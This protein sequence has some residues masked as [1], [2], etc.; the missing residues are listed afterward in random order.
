MGKKQAQS[1]ALSLKETE[2]SAIYSSPLKRASDTARAIARYHQTSVEFVPNLK[3]IAA[4]DLEGTPLDNNS[5]A[6]AKLLA[7][8]RQGES[9]QELLGGESLADLQARSWPVVQHILARHKQGLIVIV[10]HYFVTL[11]IICKTL[12]LPLNHLRR[13]RVS[14][15]SLSIL[16]FSDTRP[17]LVVL[18]NTCHLGD[19]LG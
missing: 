15:G 6:S 13:L 17:C 12:D 19:E 18:N 10:S 14:V 1:L 5:D 16:D 8:W 2:I 11:T 7:L 3:E 9:S 4:G